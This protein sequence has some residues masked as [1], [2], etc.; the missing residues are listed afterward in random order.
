[1][2]ILSES[3]G[4][5]QKDRENVLLCKYFILKNQFNFY[6]NPVHSIHYRC[7]SLVGEQ[8]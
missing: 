1:M 4:H 7:V 2:F 3:A 8:K 6:Q 5:I